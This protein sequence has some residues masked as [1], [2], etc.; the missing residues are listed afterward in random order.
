LSVELKDESSF[1]LTK[2]SIF[3]SVLAV[4]YTVG[5]SILAVHALIPQAGQGWRLCRLA[6][7]PTREQVIAVHGEAGPKMTWAERAKAGTPAEKFQEALKGKAK[8]HDPTQTAF[9]CFEVD[10]GHITTDDRL[11]AEAH[12]QIPSRN[13]ESRED[14]KWLKA[15]SFKNRKLCPCCSFVPTER[16]LRTPCKNAVRPPID[17]RQDQSSGQ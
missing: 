2:P 9:R 5:L 14:K 13:Q 11:R 12:Q 17:V 16:N 10:C 7:S 15:A 1:P 4:I 8:Q 6:G 3:L